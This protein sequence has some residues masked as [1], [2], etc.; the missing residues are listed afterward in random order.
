MSEGTPPPYDQK[1]QMVV[2]ATLKL[3]HLKP[4]QKSAYLGHLAHEVG[5]MN[6][7]VKATQKKRREGQV[8]FSE[9]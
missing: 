7:A 5:W 4:K 3:V 2:P 9:T 6:Q 1:K 8:P